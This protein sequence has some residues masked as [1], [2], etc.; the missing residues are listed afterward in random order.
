MEFFTIQGITISIY[1]LDQAPAHL[2]V[3]YGDDE[4]VISMEDRLVEGKAKFHI[5][6]IVNDFID[7]YY[8]QIM[9]AWNMAQKGE[10][11]KKLEQKLNDEQ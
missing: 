6:S 11:I 9:G 5:I 4:I 2:H 10:M 3:K 1:G 8:D 7:E